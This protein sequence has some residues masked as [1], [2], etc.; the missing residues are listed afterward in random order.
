MQS[1]DERKMTRLF[2]SFVFLSSLCSLFL[3]DDLVFAHPVPKQNHDRTIEVR[4]TPRAV[5][6]KYRLEIDEYRAVQ[7]LEKEE[8]ARIRNPRDIGRV[9]LASAA[10]ILRN[11]LIARLDEKELSFHGEGKIDDSVADHL[12]CDFTF[13]APWNPAPGQLHTFTFREANYDSED[14]DRIDLTLTA[15]TQ[16]KLQKATAPDQA[17]RERPALERRPGDDDRLRKLSATFTLEGTSTDAGLQ[18]NSKVHKAK[19]EQPKQVTK[20]PIEERSVAEIQETEPVQPSEQ[21]QPHNLW[22]LLL[23]TKRGL[24]VLLLMAAGF[25]AVHALTPGHGKTLVAAYLVGE[26]GTVWHALLLGLMTTLTHTGAVLVLA[27]VFLVSPSSAKS[28]HY[29]QGLLGGLLIT[30]LGLWLLVQRL[31]GRPDHVHLGGSHH[32]HHHDDHHHA[33]LP[34]EGTTVRWWHLALLGMR[35]GLVPCWDAILLLCLAISAQRLWLGLPLLLAFSAG[36]AGVL[37]ALGV[38][39]VWARSWAIARWGESERIRK[40]SGILPLFSA[41]LITGLGLWLCYESLHA[42]KLPEPNFQKSKASAKVGS[43]RHAPFVDVALPFLE[44]RPTGGA[45]AEVGHVLILRQAVDGLLQN[46]RIA[47]EDWA[48]A[49]Q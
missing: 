11:N 22:H 34:P 27:V 33:H 39:V 47:A 25:G 12:R 40:I 4:L 49:G 1:R 46:G 8:I 10:S 44:Q 26:R 43:L 21:Q 45:G 3:C 41:A 37:V 30:L 24:V 2:I 13:T 17:L 35:G 5:V 48:V 7:D 6:V 31:F 23:D 29:L 42:E 15:D 28:I 38:S 36:L 9:F 16:L 32:H 20:S 14:F 19:P 18:T